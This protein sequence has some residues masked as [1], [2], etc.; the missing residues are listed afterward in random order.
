LK[1]ELKRAVNVVPDDQKDWQPGSDGKVL[2]LVHPSLFSLVYTQ[3]R[4]LPHSTI[5]LSDYLDS[6]GTGETVPDPIL[7][8]DAMRDEYRH[9]AR[10]F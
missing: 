4:I 9:A 2:D 3:S 6:I 7:L 5:G 10:E 8:P 1:E